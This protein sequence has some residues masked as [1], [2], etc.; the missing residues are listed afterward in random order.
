MKALKAADSWRGEGGFSVG[1][2]VFRGSVR[3]TGMDCE[4]A[5]LGGYR[6]PWDCGTVRR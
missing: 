1:E 2:I 6:K 4:Q 3:P 5:A